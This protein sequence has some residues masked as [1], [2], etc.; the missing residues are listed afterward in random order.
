MLFAYRGIR[1]YRT[2]IWKHPELYVI[3][4][5]WWFQIPELLLYAV[6]VAGFF[7]PFWLVLWNHGILWLSI[8]YH[9]LAME[10]HH[11]NWSFQIF[12][13]ARRKT[14]KQLCFVSRDGFQDLPGPPPRRWHRMLCFPMIPI[15]ASHEHEFKF[16][17]DGSFYPIFFKLIVPWNSPMNYSQ[18]F[19]YTT[20]NCG[21]IFG[22]SLNWDI[23][24]SSI[25][26]SDFPFINHTAIG[27]P[28]LLRNPKSS[29]LSIR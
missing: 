16:P 20:W 1:S 22:G 11:P 10:C 4:T 29:T 12:Q 25:Y 19:R 23:P 27:V 24:K 15:W 8:Y 3:L 13:R 6:V 5:T 21:E 17:P 14:T 9:R 2:S 18:V 7:Y 28:H 26:R